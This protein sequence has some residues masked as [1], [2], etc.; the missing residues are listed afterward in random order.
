M[1]EEVQLPHGTDDV[2]TDFCDGQYIKDNPFFL[3]YPSAL[4][5]ILYYDD[6]EVC[7]PLGASAG[8]HKLGE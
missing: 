1:L 8:V 4:Q 5:F 2:M 6:I 3:K 7:N